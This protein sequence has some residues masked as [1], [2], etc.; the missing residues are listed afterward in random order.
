MCLVTG[1]GASYVHPVFTPLN[2]GGTVPAVSHRAGDIPLIYR[3]LQ[4][5]CF[6][7]SGYRVFLEGL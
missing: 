3:V 2:R 6:Q 1:S 7:V 5:L 4:G